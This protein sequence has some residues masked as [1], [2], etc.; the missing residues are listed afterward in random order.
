MNASIEIQ[1]LPKVEGRENVRKVVDSVIEY[2]DSTGLKYVVGPFG[3]TLE[4]DFD[5]LIEVIKNCN[6]IAVENG[7]YEVYSYIKMVYNSKGEVWTIDDKTGK[8]KE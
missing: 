5:E 6:K 7:S 4:G 8:Y 2:I 1:I 3:T